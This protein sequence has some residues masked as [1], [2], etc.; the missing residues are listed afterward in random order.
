MIDLSLYIPVRCYGYED[1]EQHTTYNSTVEVERQQVT[2]EE[3]PGII[4][5]WKLKYHLFTMKGW[6]IG[7][8][9]QSSH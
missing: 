9:I 3:M 1:G 8:H 5:A 7:Q 2:P 4:M 6:S